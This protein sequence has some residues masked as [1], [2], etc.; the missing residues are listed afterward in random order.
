M[1]P[2]EIKKKKRSSGCRPPFD[3]IVGHCAVPRLI[4]D[5]VG[6]IQQSGVKQLQTCGK[7]V[8]KFR[9]VCRRG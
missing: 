1:H 6:L 2:L 8:C 9:Y 4:C 3:K 5:F 7:D